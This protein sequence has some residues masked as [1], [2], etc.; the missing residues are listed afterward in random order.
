MPPSAGTGASP[1]GPRGMTKEKICD[2]NL[3]CFAPYLDHWTGE[4]GIPPSF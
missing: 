2:Q 1:R 3:L 4:F